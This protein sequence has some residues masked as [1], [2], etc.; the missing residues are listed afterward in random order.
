MPNTRSNS[1]A[2][3]RV[4]EQF[5]EDHQRVKK[6]Y[7]AFRKLDPEE[8]AERCEEIVQ[9]VLQELEV[10]TTLEE[11]LLY[12][13]AREK[14]E[15]ALI[16]EAEIEHE[17]AHTLIE[18]LQGMDSSED[19][20]A[21]RFTVLCE[22]VMHHVKEEEKEMFPQL[23]SARGMDWE[24]LE[25]ALDERR[26]ELEGSE[27]GEEGDEGQEDPAA[28]AEGTARTA[29]TDRSLTGLTSSGAAGGRR[30]PD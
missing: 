6:A 28:S 15:A 23:E 20:F 16:D 9:Q 25:K 19:K 4:I 13:A 27:E 24:S 7:Q 26:A 5:K 14:L 30:M 29:R 21:A 1:Q 18:Q 12:P 8:D 22:Y 3:Q 10:H 11:E 17:S 2:R